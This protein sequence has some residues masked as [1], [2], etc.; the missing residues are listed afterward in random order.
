MTRDPKSTSAV[1]S[2]R[3]HQPAADI[4]TAWQPIAE[5]ELRR[6]A[7]AALDRI[8]DALVSPPVAWLPSGAPASEQA[9]ANLSL[10]GGA[11]GQALMHAYLRHT[12]PA[13]D[14]LARASRCVESAT[15][16]VQRVEL[17][18]SLFSGFTGV[19]WVIEH[20]TGTV[21]EPTEEDPLEAIDEALCGYLA[22]QGG[23]S[24]FDLVSGLVGI[25]VYAFERLPR[26]TAEEMLHRVIERLAQRAERSPA[27]LTWRTP[28]EAQAAPGFTLG[29]FDLGLAHGVPGVVALL[30]MACF[31]DVE[32]DSAH[33]LLE[34]AVAWLRHQRLD[35]GE[36]A[37]YASSAGPG[38][39]RAASR[40]AWCYGDL[41]IAWAQWMAGCAAGEREW[42]EEALSIAIR[43]AARDPA[44]SGVRDAPLCHGAAGVA[45]VFNRFYQA[46][47]DASLAEAARAWLGRAL[48]WQEAD[49]GIGG[50]R[51]WAPGQ[52]SSGDWVNDPGL[53][54]GTAGIGL[55]LAAALT[56]DEPGWDRVLLLSTR[57][58]LEPR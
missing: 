57:E 39:T 3:G 33:A 36:S 37:A 2:A 21:L 48:E 15:D 23:P 47:S 4:R 12:R 14:H 11:A 16:G 58:R 10:A 49:A 7:D 31:Q 20:L 55:A 44:T 54:G 25:G 29:P 38:S 26:P 8:A 35:S 41:G 22:G 6:R 9:A 5:G 52:G 45:H 42:R 56:A 43:A 17:G 50:F 19:A 30:A 18:A 24:A 28:P 40:L 46:S 27:G 32:A 34:G 53:L 13:G 51:A 1:V